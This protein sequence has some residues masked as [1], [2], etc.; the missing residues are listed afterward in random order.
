[1]T[2][3]RLHEQREAD[4]QLSYQIGEPTPTL[5]LTKRRKWRS[6]ERSKNGVIKRDNKPN[7]RF[8]Y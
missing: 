7:E 2:H 6:T 4:I 1:M 5:P 3:Y 8:V